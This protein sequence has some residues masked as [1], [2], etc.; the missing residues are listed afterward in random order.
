MHNYNIDWYLC[1]KG[2]PS[3]RFISNIIKTL[4][5]D[6]DDIVSYEKAD[7]SYKLKRSFDITLP[8]ITT[9]CINYH[10]VIYRDIKIDKFIIM[11]S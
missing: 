8:I 4:G 7:I 11:V 2:D 6:S 10:I 1:F 3:V 9:K 5:L